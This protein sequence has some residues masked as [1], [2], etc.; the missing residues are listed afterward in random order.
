MMY[1]FP[2]ITIWF[3]YVLPAGLPLYWIVTTLFSIGQQY[4]IERSEDKKEKEGGD[5][6]EDKKDQDKDEDKD[7]KKNKENAEADSAA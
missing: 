7:K 5:D 3:G 6:K 2:I 4:V 1:F